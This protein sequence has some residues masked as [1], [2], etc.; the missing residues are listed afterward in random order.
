EAYSHLAPG[1]ELHISGEKNEGIKTCWQL[2]CEVF[3]AEARLK[4]AGTVYGGVLPKSSDKPEIKRSSYHE[5]CEIGEWD[6]VPIY[7]KPGVYGWDKIDAG[8]ALLI[9]QLKICATAWEPAKTILDLGCGYG[10]L[11][12]ASSW[13][14]CERRVATD[15]NAAAL[16]CTHMNCTHRGINT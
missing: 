1:G 16:I 15:N 12:F 2:A 6:G 8:S 11:T 10:F 9:E 3:S 14:N 4:K 13:I 5:L 7:S